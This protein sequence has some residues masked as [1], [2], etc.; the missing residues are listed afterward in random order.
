MNT[1]ISAMQAAGE[2]NI[3]LILGSVMIL[4]GLIAIAVAWSMTNDDRD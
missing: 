1:L 2:L 3:L 4:A